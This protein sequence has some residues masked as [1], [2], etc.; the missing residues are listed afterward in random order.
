M[1]KLRTAVSGLGRIGWQYHLPKLAAH[2]GF[3]I[4]AVADPMP[5]RLEEAGAA[6]G[7]AVYGSFAELLEREAGRLDL[8]V[9]ASPTL[10]HRQQALEAFE[11]GV[12]VF[13]DKP[14]ALDLRETD[15]IIDAMHRHGRRLMV[16]QPHRVTSECRA[17]RSILER[18]VLG[19]IHT[20]RRACTGY[21]RRN[22]W[23]A[24]L[25]NG[26]GMLNN[27]GAHY[28]D[29]LLYVTRSRCSRV[30]CSLKRVLSLGD[31]DDAVKVLMETDAGILLDL[32]ID[33]AAAQPMPP[34]QIFGRDG[35]A[36]LVEDG[37]GGA[38]FE[39][40]RLKQSGILALQGTMAAQGRA[41][42]SSA[43]LVWEE[44]RVDAG[45]A[46]HNIYE[47]CHAYFAMG[48]PP[49]VPVEETREVMRVIAEC[50]RAAGR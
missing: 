35:A 40:R 9:I 32:D 14:I 11:H 49:F 37:T 6:Y 21:E 16:Y 34:W 3:E 15:D 36:R 24:M 23:Q 1:R 42:G 33:M 38:Y 48:E 4:A 22:D 47:E 30:T 29:Q 50:R 17:A 10:Y 8:A 5:E 2:P 27:Y 45:W 26:G 31:A 44:E 43:D 19:P 20:I 41:Y 39:V 12:D 7:A 25:K 46:D 18:G 28:I 13:M